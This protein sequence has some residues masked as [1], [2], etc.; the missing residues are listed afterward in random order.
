[1]KKTTDYNLKKKL[2]I[3]IFDMTDCEGCELEF[4]NLREKLTTVA[5]QADFANWRLASDN[6]DLGPFDITFVEGTPITENDITAVKQARAASRIVV[7][8]GSCADLG[9][10]QSLIGKSGWKKGLP[11]VYG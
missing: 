3:A 11:L 7:S 2:K 10:V 4:I 6:H 8:L 1:M 9:G 5:D